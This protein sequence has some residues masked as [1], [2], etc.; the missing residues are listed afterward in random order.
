MNRIVYVAVIL[1]LALSAGAFG[2]GLTGKMMITGYGGYS[3]GFGDAFEEY[4]AFNYKYSNSAG[5]TFGA[6]FHY[7]VN[8]QFAVGGELMM[9][10]YSFDSEYTGTGSQFFGDLDAS[11]SE[12]EMAFLFNGLYPFNYSDEQAFFLSFGGGLYEYGDTE[13]GANGGIVFHRQLSPQIN[14]YVAPRFH[15]VFAS[16]TIMLLQL[17]GGVAFAI[18]G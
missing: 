9:Q 5:F 15:V 1:A 2:Q 18:G 12:T 7:F 16:E 13:F 6:I 11:V 8:E 4:E 17:S 14:L 3:V 10:S